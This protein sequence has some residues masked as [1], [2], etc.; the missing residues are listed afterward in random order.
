MI[1]NLHVLYMKT[2]NYFSVQMTSILGY[3]N[4][5]LKIQWGSLLNNIL[6]SSCN[7]ISHENMDGLEEILRSQ[8]VQIQFKPD[9]NT[10]TVYVP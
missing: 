6:W 9:V 3:E 7:L 10:S 1:K 4:S 5:K 2:N 8:L